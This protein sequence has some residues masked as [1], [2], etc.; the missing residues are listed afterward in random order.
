[1]TEPTTISVEEFDRRFD[2]G[3]ELLEYLDLEHPIIEKPHRIN[4]NLPD[5]LVTALDRRA[6]HLGIPRQAV[7]IV[8]LAERAEQEGL[9][10]KADY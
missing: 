5:W 4:F 7:A 3:E 10:P 2:D 8:W 9:A 1:M 6:K